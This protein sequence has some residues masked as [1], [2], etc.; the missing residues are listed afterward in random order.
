MGRN[1]QYAGV[2]ARAVIALLMGV[3][4][5]VPGFLVQAGVVSGS[6]L[7]IELYNYAWF[8]GIAIASLAYWA[9]MRG[10]GMKDHEMKSGS[11]S[12]TDL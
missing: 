2:N 10:H 9:M 4:P 5:N 3:L 8:I 11:A 1:G 6:G 12:G 7:L